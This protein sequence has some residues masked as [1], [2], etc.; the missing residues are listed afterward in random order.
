MRIGELAEPRARGQ[1]DADAH[2]EVQGAGRLLE[3]LSIAGAA[4]GCPVAADSEEEQLDERHEPKVVEVLQ[5]L[6]DVFLDDA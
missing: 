6:E 3:S 5:L 2:V 4:E 1:A